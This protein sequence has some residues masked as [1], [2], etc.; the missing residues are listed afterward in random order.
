MCN[1]IGYNVTNY[2][3]TVVK[4][5]A[6]DSEFRNA[7]SGG[8]GFCLHHLPAL[9]SMGDELL[10]G[11]VADEWNSELAAL[12]ARNLEADR[13]ALEAFTWQFDYQSEKK[14]PD[15]AQ[16]AVPRAVRRIAGYGP[17]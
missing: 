8:G 6:D 4:L 13:D 15:E 7:L 2:I 14:T 16:D 17:R 10:S 9:Y 12:E 11:S 1:R 5:F 3:Y